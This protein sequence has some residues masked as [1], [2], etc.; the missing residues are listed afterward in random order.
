MKELLGDPVLISVLAGFVVSFAL[1]VTRFDRGA[2]LVMCLVLLATIEVAIF[3]GQ[4]HLTAKFDATVLVWG[5]AVALRGAA[6]LGIVLLAGP[7]G[8]TVSRLA[9]REHGVLLGVLSLGP[10]GLGLLTS[11]ITL[12]IATRTIFSEATSSESGL[13]LL[14]TAVDRSSWLV[15][16]GTVASI[17]TCVAVAIV[18]TRAQAKVTAT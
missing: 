9:G 11:S 4:R 15:S 12:Q 14:R 6:G 7:F 1:S 13:A 17:A 18:A 2:L 16:G 5:R 3:D 8:K 10:F